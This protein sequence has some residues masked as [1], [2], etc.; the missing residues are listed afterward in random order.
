MQSSHQNKH[1]RSIF[2]EQTRKT[3][4]DW[5]C[6]TIG[7]IRLLERSRVKIERLWSTSAPARETVMVP[8]IFSPENLLF[9]YLFRGENEEKPRRNRPVPTPFPFH[10]KNRSKVSKSI[11][12]LKCTLF[13]FVLYIVQF[14]NGFIKHLFSYKENNKLWHELDYYN[15]AC[16]HDRIIVR[17]STSY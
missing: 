9:R 10:E 11:L 4:V 12:N 14:L 2:A 1:D 5:W 13:L 8:F 17:T 15:K 7:S 16:L 3:M 6:V